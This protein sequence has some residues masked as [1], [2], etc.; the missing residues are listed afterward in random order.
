MVTGVKFGGA[1]KAAGLA[2]ALL[3]ST[4]LVSACSKG[5]SE[6]AA[7]ESSASAAP[8]ETVK[9][10][11][12]QSLSGT[13]AI[14]EVTVKNAEMM[15]IDEINAAGGVMG[16]QI[17]PVVEDGASDPAVFAQK[18]AKLLESDHTAT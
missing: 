11:V 13:M 7:S 17:A 4:A 3:A 18:A 12:L 8:G 1:V 2:A 15:A 9:V 10:G 5:G 6:T 14:S 16:H